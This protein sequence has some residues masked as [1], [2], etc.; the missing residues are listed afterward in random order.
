ME[1]KEI[2]TGVAGHR[3]RVLKKFMQYGGEVFA[4]YELLELLL[5]QAIPRKDVKPLAKELLARFGHLSAV[6]QA[7]PEQLKQVKGIGDHTAAFLKLILYAGQRLTQEKLVKAPVLSDWNSMLDYA[8]MLYAGETVEKLRI[9]FLNQKLQLTHTEIHQT[10]TINHVP[11]YPREV[12]KRALNLNASAIILMHNHPS[13][14][15]VPSGDDIR[16][17]QEI[18]KLLNTIPIR[19]LDHLIIGQNKKCYSFR[20]HHAL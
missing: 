14:D 3:E 10:G 8:Q 1:N 5:M 12:L 11:I 2:T 19:L 20:A 17:T 4:D 18:E 13:G 7:T 16:A 9:L 15:P 6:I